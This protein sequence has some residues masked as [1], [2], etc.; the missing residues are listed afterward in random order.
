MADKSSIE[1][2]DATWNIV[3]G[4]SRVSR[5]CEN[6]WAE[7]EAARRLRNHPSRKGLTD[8]N[9][10]WTGQA[11]FNWEWLDKPLRWRKPRKIFVAASGDLFHET[12]ADPWIDRVWAVMALCQRHRFQ[13][14]TKRPERMR[15]Y[16]RDCG[17]RVLDVID[18]WLAYP[19]LDV[20]NPISAPLRRQL[21]RERLARRPGAMLRA[22]ESLPNA[23]IGTSVED[24]P[25][26]DERIPAL[27]RI[28]AAVL[29]VSVEPLLGAVDLT[30]LQSPGLLDFNALSGRSKQWPSSEFNPIRWVVA[31]G[32][33]GPG[34]RLMDPAWA[35]SLRNQCLSAGVPFFFKQWGGI[36]SKA[37][38]CEL[39]G[40]QWRQMPG[41]DPCAS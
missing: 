32:E 39:D 3:T 31:G 19:D 21:V 33:S 22:G 29:W 35:N 13:I 9:G 34:A 18:E 28:A 11:R 7:R 41:E 23:W 30:N 38:G 24:Q 2:T 14:L 4:C 40:R 12:V 1:W 10:R 26:A 6:C 20:A 15:V 37:G 8:R 17:T 5:G 36:T 25:T 16:A 27:A